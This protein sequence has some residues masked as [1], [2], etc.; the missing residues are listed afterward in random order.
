MPKFKYRKISDVEKVNGELQESIG[1]IMTECDTDRPNERVLPQEDA[2][3][4]VCCSL[5]VLSSNL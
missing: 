3:S 1:G 4:F 5:K 2:V